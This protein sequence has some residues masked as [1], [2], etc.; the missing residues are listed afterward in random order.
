M[1]SDDDAFVEEIVAKFLLNTC[2]IHPQMTQH[3]V[4]AAIHCV[5]LAT[6]HPVDQADVDF[7]PLTTGSVA[8]FYLS[9][10]HI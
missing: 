5:K 4:M 8:E 10:I 6:Q 1:M 2:Q 3:R 7:I 9:L